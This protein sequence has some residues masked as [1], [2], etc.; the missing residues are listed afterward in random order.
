MTHAELLAKIGSG[1]YKDGKDTVLDHVN[2]QL[3]NKALR[4]VV[5][6]HAPINTGKN[7]DSCRVC[8][9]NYSQH[10]Y[11]PCPTVLAIEEELK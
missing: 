11:Y 7:Y 2:L 10:Y 4:R 8:V 6:I 5:E 9:D 3:Q 1:T